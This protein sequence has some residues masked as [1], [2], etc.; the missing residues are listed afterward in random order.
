MTIIVVLDIPATAETR[1][2]IYTTLSEALVETRRF[3]G[4]E[5]LELL[6]NQEDDAN[7]VVYER[8]Q[9]REHY[10][11]YLAFRQESGFSAKFRAMIPGTVVV[12]KFDI[13]RV[14]T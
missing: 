9:S 4:N 13:D 2:A 12:R 5:G 1:D 6:I 11:R 8:W 3:D 14:Y 7:I 10:D